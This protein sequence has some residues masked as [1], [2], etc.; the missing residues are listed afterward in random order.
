[1]QE[2]KKQ[3]EGN[4]IT[5]KVY[6]KYYQAILDDKKTFEVRK[7]DREI[8]PAIGDLLK[9]VEIDEYYELT[10][11]STFLMVTY[12]LS[13]FGLWDDD[14]NPMFIMSIRKLSLTEIRA[15]RILDNNR[16]GLD[17]E[18][19]DRNINPDIFSKFQRG[20]GFA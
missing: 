15:L 12:V 14:G 8:K 4:I 9:L 13:D 17:L 2:Q 3:T 1:M 20:K 11:R 19:E 10:E 7:D 16:Y 6:S 18:P 5:Y